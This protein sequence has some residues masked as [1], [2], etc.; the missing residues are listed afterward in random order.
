MGTSVPLK[1][2][3]DYPQDALTLFM[4]MCYRR[5]AISSEALMASALQKVADDVY[6]CQAVPR[7][8]GYHAER[9]KREE[10]CTICY[11]LKRRDQ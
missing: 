1:A 9:T 11:P 6:A 7:S 3:S 10:R 8:T 4:T 5:L 2:M